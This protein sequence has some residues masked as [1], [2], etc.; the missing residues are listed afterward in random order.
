MFS[1]ENL[2]HKWANGSTTEKVLRI[3]KKEHD[4]LTIVYTIEQIKPPCGLVFMRDGMGLFDPVE[5]HI[6]VLGVPTFKEYFSIRQSFRVNAQG[7]KLG[8]Y[9]SGNIY[10]ISNKPKLLEWLEE[11]ERSGYA[12]VPYKINAK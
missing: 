3:T 7:D 12:Q 4:N 2:N 8:G 9:Q 5:T 11:K 6:S 10:D 1:W